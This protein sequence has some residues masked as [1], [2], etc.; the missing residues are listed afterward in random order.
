MPVRISINPQQPN[1]QTAIINDATNVSVGVITL[2]KVREI[3]TQIGG[4]IGLKNVVLT[5]S[6]DYTSLAGDLVVLNGP[7]EVAPNVNLPSATE[8]AMVGVKSYSSAG[9]FSV[10]PV[11]G[12]TIDNEISFEVTPSSILDVSAVFVSDG[13]SNWILLSL[14]VPA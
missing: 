1:I 5:D 4:G 13:I 6:A 12:E 2:N 11:D 10:T 7:P 9:S 8:L 3:A 14:Y